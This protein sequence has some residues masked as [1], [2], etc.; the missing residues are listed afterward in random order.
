[1]QETRTAGVAAQRLRAGSGAPRPPE[2]TPLDRY[3][4]TTND[5]VASERVARSFRGHFSSERVKQG[6]PINHNPR[7]APV[8]HPTLETEGEAMVVA[9]RAWLA[10]PRA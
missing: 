6:I 7:F 10:S 1:M 5:A 3:A 9:A 2:I 4:L 8:L